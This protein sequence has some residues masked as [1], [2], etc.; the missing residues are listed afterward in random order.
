[1]PEPEGT[2]VLSDAELVEED[3]AGR[4]ESDGGGG[5]REDGERESEERARDENIEGAL[6]R[7]RQSFE[8]PRPRF[9]QRQIPDNPKT[10]PADHRFER[11]SPAERTRG[12]APRRALRPPPPPPRRSRRE[13]APAGGR[14]GRATGEPPE[15]A[16]D[17]K[18]ARREQRRS[19]EPDDFDSRPRVTPD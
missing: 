1:L 7:G 16:E 4:R 19:H 14:P 17:R 9:E 12:A 5:H 6:A 15:R 2:A 13:N 10:E 11:G 8:R 3:S 18:V